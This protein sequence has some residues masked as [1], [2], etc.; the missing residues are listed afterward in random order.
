MTSR[1]KYTV[2][3]KLASIARCQSSR[4]ADEKSLGR[5]TAGIG[6]ADI[7]AAEL[8]GNGGHEALHGIGVGHVEGLGEDIHVML[9]SDL[10]RAG[11][12]RIL[13]A[14]AHRHAAALGGEG[15]GGGESESLTGGGNQGNAAF[16]SHVH[17][18]GIIN[19]RGVRQ[20]S[21]FDYRA[22]VSLG[23]RFRL[24]GRNRRH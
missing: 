5:R 15:F 2:L 9:F 11:C 13:A 14:R 7:D 19:G 6:H 1:A 12:E 20:A 17:E 23:T 10:L 3:R 24:P 16:Q 22:L 8:A 18:A 4:V 21:E